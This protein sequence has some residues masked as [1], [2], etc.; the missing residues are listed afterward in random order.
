MIFCVLF[1]NCSSPECHQNLQTFVPR[2]SHRSDDAIRKK[3]DNIVTIKFGWRQELVFVTKKGE[4]SSGY[5]NLQN[6]SNTG[7]NTKWSLSVVNGSDIICF[8]LHIEV[9]ELVATDEI[10]QLEYFE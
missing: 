1:V 4:V 7:E 6:A 9:V 8:T 2:R 5:D 3:R 10:Q